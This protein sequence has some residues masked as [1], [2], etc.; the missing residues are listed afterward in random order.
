MDKL[1]VCRKKKSG[2][3]LLSCFVFLGIIY[4]YPICF[5][6]VYKLFFHNDYPVDRNLLDD[7]II[8][9]LALPGSLPWLIRIKEYICILLDIRIKKLTTI[10]VKGCGKPTVEFFDTHVPGTENKND[11]YFYWK[12]IDDSNKKHKFIIFQDANILKGKTTKH[13]YYVTY[14]K[15]SKIVINIEREH[16]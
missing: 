16:S 7:L 14:Y 4:I 2:M 12:A 10:K 8:V 9:L 11:I 13:S 1:E 6:S 15:H 3:F 5:F